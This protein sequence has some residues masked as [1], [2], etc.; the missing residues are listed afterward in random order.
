MHVTEQG[1]EKKK[2]N[3]FQDQS[4]VWVRDRQRNVCL[5][6]ALSLKRCGTSRWMHNYFTPTKIL[7]LHDDLEAF[8]YPEKSNILERTID[9]WLYAFW[10]MY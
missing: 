1:L 4:L 10:G 8:L 7:E 3:N 2:F 6:E 9:F 5:Q